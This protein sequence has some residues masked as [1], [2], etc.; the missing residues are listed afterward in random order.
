MVPVV[1]GVTILI[2][3]IM[4]FI[5][6][7]PAKLML[8]PDSTPEQ[9]EAKRAELG[10]NDPYLTRLGKYVG[11]IVRVFGAHVNSDFP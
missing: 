4:F 7:D 2:F 11:G 3:T 10:L 8:G 1:L 6:G 5:P 9:V